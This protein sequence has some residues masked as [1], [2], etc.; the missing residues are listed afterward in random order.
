MVREFFDPL[1]LLVSIATSVLTFIILYIAFHRKANRWRLQ[2]LAF[3]RK[4]ASVHKNYQSEAPA[5][6]HSRAYIDLNKILMRNPDLVEEASSRLADVLQRYLDAK[7]CFVEK[8][9]GSGGILTIAGSIENKLRRPVSKLSLV[10]DVISI[11]LGGEPIGNGDKVILVQDVIRTGYET[12]EAA[13]KLKRFNAIVFATVALVDCEELVKDEAFNKTG[14]KL[15]SILK[16]SEI[17]E[18]IAKQSCRSD[19]KVMAGED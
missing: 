1:N 3:L 19:V 15:I 12:V 13:Q 7:I 9:F 17:E 2:R 11:S 6:R 5:Y 18:Y 8:N 4:I 10:R 14:I 16:L